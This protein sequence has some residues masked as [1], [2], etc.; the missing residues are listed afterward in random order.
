MID[1]AFDPLEALMMEDEDF[2]Q[3]ETKVSTALSIMP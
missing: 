1:E 2:M 3:E